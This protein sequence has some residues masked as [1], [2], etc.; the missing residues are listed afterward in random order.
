MDGLRHLQKDSGNW[1]E[2]FIRHAS[3]PVTDFYELGR[4]IVR[5]DD[6]D[7]AAVLYVKDAYGSAVSSGHELELAR[8]NF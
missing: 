5:I 1:N 4:P 6:D 8:R 3:A 7:H 2:T